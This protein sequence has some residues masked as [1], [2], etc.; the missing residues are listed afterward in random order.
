[1]STS[2]QNRIARKLI[3]ERCLIAADVDKTIVTQGAEREK[4]DFLRQVGPQ[5][6]Q[7][8]KLGARLAFI[9]GNSLEEVTDRFL[10]WFLH[11]LCYFDE[12]ELLSQFHL[13]CNS[14]GVY[15]HLSPK[16][17]ELRRLI[18]A[19]ITDSDSKDLPDDIFREV[20]ISH[21]QS[22]RAMVHPRFIDDAYLERCRIPDGDAQMIRQILEDEAANYAANLESKRNTFARQYMLDMVSEKGELVRPFVDLRYVAYGHDGHSTQATVQITLKPILSFHQGHTKSRLFGK[23]LR[24]QLIHTI[25]S[26]L[27]ASGL[28]HYV[29]RPGGRASI[30]VTQDKLNKAFALEFLIDRLNLH[31]IARNG[32][33]FGSNTI[34]FGDEV[35]V[36]SGNDYAVTRIPGLMVVAVNPQRDLVPLLSQVLVPSTILEGP[37]ATVQVLTHFNHCAERLLREYSTLADKKRPISVKNAIE[38]VKEEIYSHRTR[39]MINTLQT[40]VEDW[41]ALHS[42]ISLIQRKDPNNRQRLVSLLRELNAILLQFAEDSVSSVQGR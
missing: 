29:A 30:D 36:G 38:S 24:N 22:G 25:Q 41:Q 32:E 12:L 3:T 7:A 40:P 18:D 8:A 26:R 37:D 16:D 19:H 35:I 4:Q 42:L 14:G 39:E 15:I 5:L 31:G 33:Q 21:D 28:V 11:Q 10:R 23:D 6:I 1:L 20:T 27:D 17:P 13:F 9:S 2:S 34:Y